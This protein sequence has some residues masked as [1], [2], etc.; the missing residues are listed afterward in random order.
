[1]KEFAL[2][3]TGISPTAGGGVGAAYKLLSTVKSLGYKTTL[4]TVSQLHSSQEYKKSI[5]NGRAFPI[6]RVSSIHEF[7]IERADKVNKQNVVNGNGEFK[8]TSELLVTHNRIQIESGNYRYYNISSAVKKVSY[9]DIDDKLTNEEYYNSSFTKKRE[10]S[11]DKNGYA[12]TEKLYTDSGKWYLTIGRKYVLHKGYIDTYFD[13]YDK[14]GEI[15]RLNDIRQFQQYFVSEITTSDTII[16]IDHPSLYTTF[17]QNKL[18]NK[19]IFNF[20]NSHLYPNSDN[21]KPGYDNVIF[22]LGNAVDRLVV[23]TFSELEDLKK[24]VPR[25]KWKYIT[26]IPHSTPQKDIVIPLNS[27]PKNKFISL[28]RLEPVKR[29]DIMIRAFKAVV[30]YDSSA[31]LDIYGQGSEYESLIKLTKKLNLEK[32]INFFGFT[33]SVNLAYQSHTALLFT[34]AYEGFGMTLMESLSNGTPSIAFDIKY[35]PRDIITSGK[36]GY[37]LKDGD[38]AGL[39]NSMLKL[40]NMS[41]FGINENALLNSKRFSEMEYRINI[42]KLLSAL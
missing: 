13:V 33:N 6:D 10:T 38:V 22:N 30:E 19:K 25:D 32:N 31:V 15:K 16:W 36:D 18:K 5:I 17:V 9:F 1:M 39:T 41:D 21:I 12:I 29:V 24:I 40:M 8:I 35:G 20:Q 2:V 23:L 7:F 3:T 4:L 27:R 42:E 11:F 37:L 34:S 28:G 26:V 14:N